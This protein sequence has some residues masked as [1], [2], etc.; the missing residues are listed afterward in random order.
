MNLWH[1]VPLG[2]KAPEQINIIVEI[3]KGSGNKYEVDKETGMIALDRANYSAATY[4]CEYAFAPQTLWEDGDALDILLLA[5]YP[6]LPGVLV[7]AR[8]IAMMDMIDTGESDT[9]IIC[10]PIKDQRWEN[11]KDLGDIN[12]HTLKEIKHFFETY[13]ELK[14]DKVEVPGFKPRADALEAINQSIDLYKKKFSK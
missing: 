12:P 8:P 4:P 10:V 1:D 7:K 5:T 3:S 9:K 2:D 6:V 14:G 11:V 13:K